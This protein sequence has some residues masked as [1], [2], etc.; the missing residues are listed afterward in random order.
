[1]GPAWDENYFEK[2]LREI[3]KLDRSEIESKIKELA[4]QGVS[5]KERQEKILQK[6][7]FPQQKILEFMLLQQCSRLYDQKK[8]FLTQA[9]Y[10]FSFLVKEISK[11]LKLEFSLLHYALPHEITE[12]LGGK[13]V[14]NNDLLDQRKESSCILTENGYSRYLT[15][16]E[17]ATWLPYMEKSAA[18][19]TETKTSGLAAHS[20]K[21]QARVSRILAPRHIGNMRKGDVLVTAMTSVDFVPAM[22]MASAIV[23]DLGGITSHAAIVSRELGIPCIVGTK[24]A[25]AVLRDGDLVEVD[26]DNGNV[27]LIQRY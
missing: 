17:A 11:R 10:H 25:T 14:L 24:N 26:A 8:E 15:H 12:S 16:N 1:M 5:L 22:R 3:D 27:K 23:T 21:V 6:Y 2:R 7:N 20:G 13:R 4:H 9:H 18:E 19:I